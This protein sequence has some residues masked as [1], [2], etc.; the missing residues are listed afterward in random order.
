VITNDLRLIWKEATMTYLR[1]ALGI[2]LKRLATFNINPKSNRLH[3]RDVN[4]GYFQAFSTAATVLAF[5]DYN[6]KRV[7]LF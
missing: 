6:F 2:F 5:P 7:N 3:I 4:L 1:N